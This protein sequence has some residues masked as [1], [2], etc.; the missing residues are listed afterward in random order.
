MGEKEMRTKK[1]SHW[2]RLRGPFEKGW[3]GL[4]EKLTLGPSPNSDITS[5]TVMSEEIEIEH[6]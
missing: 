4:V 1:P 6:G 2:L 5:F 3:S